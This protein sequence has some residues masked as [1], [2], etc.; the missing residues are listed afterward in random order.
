MRISQVAEPPLA[1]LVPGRTNRCQE[2]VTVDAVLSDTW[3]EPVPPMFNEN[4]VEIEPDATRA[5]NV[6]TYAVVAETV[7]G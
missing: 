2:V 3:P 6:N 1:P 4:V 7:L 5:Q